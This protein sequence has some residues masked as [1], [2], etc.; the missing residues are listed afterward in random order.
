[1]KWLTLAR[2]L[3]DDARGRFETFVA[4]SPKDLAECAA[5]L[6]SVRRQE[7]RRMSG[8]SALAT[9][10][11]SEESARSFLL[12]VRDT[13]TRKIVGCVR[14][15]YADSVAHEPS[16]QREYRLDLIPE[17]LWPMTGIAAR[18]VVEPSMRKTAASLV[19]TRALYEMS[20]RVHQR[21]LF[22]VS[23]EPALLS[24]YTRMGYRPLGRIWA[25][26][27]GGFRIPTVLVG[28]DEE[29]LARVRSP[30]L[31]VL[32]RTPRPWPQ[33]GLRWLR[34]AKSL[35]P[36]DPGA[37]KWGSADLRAPHPSVLP[38]L[39]GLSDEG[40]RALLRNAMEVQ[41]EPGDLAFREGDGVRGLAVVLDGGVTRRR[42]GQETGRLGPGGV[43]GLLTTSLDLP[44]VESIVVDRPS[45][46]LL[47]LSR[48][49]TE[50]L[51]SAADRAAL[52][53][54]MAERLASRALHAAAPAAH[55]PGP[56]PEEQRA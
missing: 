39:R 31:P 52:W 53:Q 7:L 42:G 48:S 37:R 33:E 32:R 10:G 1:M 41:A 16:A 13:A 2:N 6:D 47:L 55:L 26:P 15:V 12:A 4:E 51:P 8:D 30:L 43:A 54:N 24:L 18:M 50:R 23:C 35:F 14:A 3:I 11:F 17:E 27:T 5:L 20:I 25:K 21:C 34:D 19:L 9:S 36:E 45:T 44:R 22:L 29:H 38:L 28:H 40:K 49:A 46:R 56:A